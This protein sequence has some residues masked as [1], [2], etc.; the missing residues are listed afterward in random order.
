MISA[1]PGIRAHGRARGRQPLS[2]AVLLLAMALALTGQAQPG[3]GEDILYSADGGGNISIVDGR[4]VTTL[5]GNVRVQQG[6]TRLYGDTATLE[7]DPQSGE[8]ERVTVRG[9]PARFEREGES[10]GEMITGHSESI[11][12]YTE[13]TGAQDGAVTV[14]EFIG[15]ATFNRGRTALQCARIRHLPETGETTSSGPC[16]GVVAPQDL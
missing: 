2:V 1:E 4:R 3:D 9:T 10:A 7:Q 12:Y 6:D 5:Q 15:E 13:N 8:I 11:L 16:S 14:V